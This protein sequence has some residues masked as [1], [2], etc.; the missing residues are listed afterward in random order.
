ML[1]ALS[2]SVGESVIGQKMLQGKRDGNRICIETKDGVGK[3]A[4]SCNRSAGEEAVSLM[5]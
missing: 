1:L 4:D 2:E 5:E 3:T